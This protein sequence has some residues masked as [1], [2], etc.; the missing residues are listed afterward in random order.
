MPFVPN[1]AI[2]KVAIDLQQGTRPFTNVVHVGAPANPD[3]AQLLTIATLVYD[4][5][6]DAFLPLLSNTV[7]AQSATAYSMA[8]TTA[9][10]AVYSPTT[11]VVGDVT[12]DPLPL[13]S[14]AVLT[15]RTNARGR[16]G[17]GRMY[18]SGWGELSSAASSLT[19]A[20]SAALITA[21][22]AFR[23]A[24][25]ASSVTLVVY[26]T[27]SEGDFRTTGVAFPVTSIV[28]RSAVFGSQRDRNNR[29]SSS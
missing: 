4:A 6:T 10:V 27:Q 23:A 3:E 28:L 18:I 17:R 14:A 26:S 20:A 21:A 22:S 1:V 12:G 9:P 7:V 2:A 5:Y 24:L 29:E 16:S 11:P 13:Q 8:S 15:L 25:L 19:P